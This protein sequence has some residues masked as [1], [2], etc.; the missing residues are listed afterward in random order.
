MK[1]LTTIKSSRRRAG[2]PRA[3]GFTLIELLVVIA[4]IAILASLLLPS[5]AKA[6]QKAQRTLCNSNQRQL[7]LAWIMYADDNGEI[8]PPN[9]NNSSG[10][11]GTITCW[12]KGVM[13]FDSSS[14]TYSDNTNTAFL[15]DPKN[16]LLAP[17]SGGGSSI[18]KCPGDTVDA[19]NGSRVRSMSMNCMMNGVQATDPSKVDQTCSNQKAGSVCRVYGKTTDITAP[20]PSE[21]W[22]FIDENCDSLNDGFFWVKMYNVVGVYNNLWQDLPASYHGNS[23][24]LSFADGHAEI[25]RW[26]DP[27]V[28][29]HVPKSGWNSQTGKTATAPYDD[30]RWLQQRTTALK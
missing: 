23:G 29:D 18:Y 6:K 9:M 14:T 12:I 20:V 2:A 7:A 24:S 11:Y 22:V 30:L 10:N 19:G 5:L 27:L 8:V 25:K 16:A 26:T 13:T 17:Y 3:S 1:F 4:I 15:T 21:A 28:T